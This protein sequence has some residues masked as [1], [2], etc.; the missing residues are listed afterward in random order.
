[1]NRE[2]HV[3]IC[4]GLGVKFPGPTRQPRRLSDPGM[5]ASPPTPG[6][7]AA[8]QLTDASGHKATS[9]AS[10]LSIFSAEKRVLAA[11]LRKLI[12][13]FVSMAARAL[14]PPHGGLWPVCAVLGAWT[15]PKTR[16]VRQVRVAI[17]GRRLQ[18]HTRRVTDPKGGLIFINEMLAPA[19]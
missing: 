10:Q 8:T 11:P 17:G 14:P 4:E 19:S 13:H 3:R 7:M 16:E 9:A 5:S 2:V 15:Q 12:K 6:R 1:M 18:H